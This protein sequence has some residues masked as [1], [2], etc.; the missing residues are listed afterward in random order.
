MIETNDSSPV[1]DDDGGRLSC[2]KNVT[3]SEWLKF[4]CSCSVSA[5]VLVAD[6]SGLV[7]VIRA[8][9]ATLIWNIFNKFYF[10]FLNLKEF[11]FCFVFYFGKRQTESDSQRM[12]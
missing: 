11:V 10:C 1:A 9:D 7:S 4:V 12:E 6:G 3:V 5:C 2:A 8:P